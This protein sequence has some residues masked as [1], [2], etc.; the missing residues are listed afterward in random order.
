MANGQEPSEA[1]GPDDLLDVDK[2][3]VLRTDLEVGKP[4]SSTEG[5]H[6]RLL[7]ALDLAGAACLAFAL[8][9]VPI[10]LGLMVMAGVWKA[11]LNVALY[12][13]MLGAVL[14]LH[15][16]PLGA[17]CCRTR[18]EPR[19]AAV[20]WLRRFRWCVL[21]PLLLGY[22]GLVIGGAVMYH[23][24]YATP[25]LKSGYDASLPVAVVGSG[26][27]G[28][29]AAWLLAQGGR[30]VTVFE[31]DDQIGG[32]SKSWT[33]VRD[34]RNLTV[35]LGFIFNSEHRYVLYKATAAHFQK[36][37]VSTALNVSS[38]VDGEF[39]DNAGFAEEDEALA[40][41]IDK[42]ISFV[43]EPEDIGRY[44]TPL[45]LWLR[46]NGFS[47]RFFRR[48][49]D[50]TLAVLFVTKMGLK[51]QSAQAVLNHF[52][53]EGFMH[54]RYDMPKVQ[55]NPAGS[56][57]MWRDVVA[58]FTSTGRAQV[59]L[60]S[61]VATV[62]QKDGL[63]ALT[64]ADGSVHGGYGDVVMACPANV[65]A[66]IVHGRP[67][68]S[69]VVSMISYTEAHVALHTDAD[70]TILPWS[71]QGS[72]EVLYFIEPHQGTVKIG[73][74]FQDD[75]SDLLLTVHGQGVDPLSLDSA[76]TLWSTKW[77][78]HYFSLWEIFVASK[79][80]PLFNGNGGLHYAG[81]YIV[82]MGHESAI[83]AGARAACQVG[84]PVRPMRGTADPL[85]SKVLAEACSVQDVR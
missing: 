79:L 22:L 74:I 64:L 39:W 40:K 43:N 55:F 62:E 76:K 42:F 18:T 75:E 25:V 52:K 69:V 27:S 50:S 49:L 21:F 28:L 38:H 37:L 82:G 1:C 29:S 77:S 78:H 70:R 15:C 6:Q 68:Q 61:R 81:D 19:L 2:Q 51:Q 3:E 14:L 41:E 71:K 26:P 83:R 72:T 8:F 34:G 33:D 59:M 24:N 32:H 44:L 30:K 17:I 36:T 73:K 53:M 12:T 65:Q 54:L 10:T 84:L 23:T 63:W 57:N 7:R 11:G 13:T 66:S 47:D 45:G 35:D 60:N 48:C 4:A 80:V 9:L 58:D 16:L 31:A 5:K 46:L 67:L 20:R 56:Q 85:Y